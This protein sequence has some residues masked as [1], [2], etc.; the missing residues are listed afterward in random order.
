MLNYLIKLSKEVKEWPAYQLKPRQYLEQFPCA[1]NPIQQFEK[2]SGDLS[3]KYQAA[4][5]TWKDEKY[6]QLGGIVTDCTTAL[7]K[8]IKEL[9]DCVKKLTALQ[10]AIA[11]YEQTSVK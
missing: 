7:N 5:T 3:K 4:G 11:E 10:K 2:A 9:Q 1:S 8:P 6:K